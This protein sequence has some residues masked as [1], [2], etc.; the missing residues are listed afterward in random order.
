M[1]SPRLQ[2]LVTRVP[3]SK[4]SIQ[5]SLNIGGPPSCTSAAGSAVAT[6]W[7]VAPWRVCPS[8]AL[9]FLEGGPRMGKGSTADGE[10]GQPTGTAGAK[11]RRTNQVL[12]V[13]ARFRRSPSF[14]STVGDQ[15][16]NSTS[17]VSPQVE[18]KL[19][20]KASTCPDPWPSPRLG[21][22][23]NADFTSVVGVP[24]KSRNGSKVNSP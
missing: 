9:H 15:L 23:P 22:I 10:L 20:P 11:R 5:P 12:Q 18:S 1:R 16:A 13:A 24:V 17:A 8:H 7:G 14:R 21:L 19:M 3:G 4:R 6:R 2:T